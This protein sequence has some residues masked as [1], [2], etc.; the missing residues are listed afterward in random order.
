MCKRELFPI[1]WPFRVKQPLLEASQKGFLAD[2]MGEKFNS[3][4]WMKNFMLQISMLRRNIRA[5]SSL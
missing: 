4:G 5:F 3:K 2:L 1:R